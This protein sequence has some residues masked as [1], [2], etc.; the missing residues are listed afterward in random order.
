MKMLDFNDAPKQ[1]EAPAPYTAEDIDAAVI[2]QLRNYTLH[3]FPN[4]Q[5]NRGQAR[6]GSL[7]GE[8]GESLVVALDGDDAGQWIDHNTDERGNA[9]QLWQQ[10]NNIDFPTALEQIAQWLGLDSRPLKASP[11]QIKRN[12]QP[13]APPAQLGAPDQEWYYKDAAGKIIAT[14]K[15]HNL[16]DGKKTFRVWDAVAGKAQQPDPK[17]LYNIPG[18]IDA[19]EII[20]VEGEKAAD[21]LIAE[22]YAAT[23]LMSGG[24]SRLDKT[25][26]TYIAGKKCNLWPD[27]DATGSKWMAGLQT[28]LTGL[29]CAVRAVIPPDFLPKKGDAADCSADQIHAALNTKRFQLRKAGTVKK[30]PPPAFLIQDYIIEIG[31]A[32]IVGPSGS[33]KSFIG[34]D[35]A[36]CTA[37][38]IEW[39]GLK[40]KKVKCAVYIAAEGG[41]GMGS[42]I[43]AF[44]NK[45]GVDSDS[46]GFHLLPEAINLVDPATDIPD[47]HETLDEVQPN[48]IV[49]DTLARSFA[50][51]DENSTKDMNQFIDNCGKLQVRYQCLVII[52][53]HTGKDVERGA[54]GSSAFKAAL[55]SEFSVKRIEGTEHI[56][57]VTSKQKDAPEA[58]PLHLRLAKVEVANEATGQIETSCVL[59]LDETIFAGR[60]Q[61]LGDKQRAILTLFETENEPLSAPQIIEKTGL[62]KAT[63]YEF[64]KDNSEGGSPVL[65]F[66]QSGTESG[67]E[68][69]YYRFKT[70]G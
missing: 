52:I 56:S 68:V 55:D 42:R 4:A 39:H 17:P 7:L 70:K 28:H 26:F 49:V 40:V 46:V 16:T 62:A 30:T 36:L 61:K 32:A 29:G 21:A 20:F 41:A 43:S 51:G 35:I 24:N 58:R 31:M 19:A 66:G 2:D 44:D 34:L 25:D 10:A 37:H 63:V 18:I 22:G 67:T 38:G 8:Q 33:G 1:A 12:A 60:R 45:H 3:L 48:M 50:G 69:K 11:A 57:F 47:L 64:L 54:R 23:S 13:K 59:M 27:K 9:I 14:V 15:R 6:I 65:V 5:I 53:H